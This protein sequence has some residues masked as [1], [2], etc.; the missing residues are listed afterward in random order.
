[1]TEV[2]PADD[3]ALDTS[4][5]QS[6][7]DAFLQQAVRAERLSSIQTDRREQEVPI[8]LVERLTPP[9]KQRFQDKRMQWN[10]PA[11]AFCLGVSKPIT[12]TGLGDTHLHGLLHGLYV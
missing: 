5:L 11:R 3:L 6:R 10:R 8:A 2:V 1:M 12:Q 7:S 9:F 4:A